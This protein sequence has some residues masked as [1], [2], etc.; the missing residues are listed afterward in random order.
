MQ[1]SRVDEISRQS[2]KGE[3]IVAIVPDRVFRN[4]DLMRHEHTFYQVEGVYVSRRVNV[5][6][7][8]ATLQEFAGILRQQT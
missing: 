8:I 1:K 5:G 7:L 2:G 4:E 6:N 3:V